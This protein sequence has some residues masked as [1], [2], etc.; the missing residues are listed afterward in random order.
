MLTYWLLYRYDVFQVRS[1][2]EGKARRSGD[3]HL[4]GIQVQ[5]LGVQGLHRALQQCVP[6]PASGVEPH[7]EGGHLASQPAGQLPGCECLMSCHPTGKI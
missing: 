2:A 6:F 7:G 4:L 5:P 3:E 1:Q